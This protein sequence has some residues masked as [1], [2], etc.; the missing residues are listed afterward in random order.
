MGLT[1]YSFYDY[2]FNKKRRTNTKLDSNL[3]S[4]TLIKYNTIISIL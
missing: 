4:S 3:T 2:R 1:Y